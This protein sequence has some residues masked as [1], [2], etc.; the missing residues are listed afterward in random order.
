M[1]SSNAKVIQY[2]SALLINLLMGL[3]KKELKEAIEGQLSQALMSI[4]Q[5]LSAT[6][7]PPALG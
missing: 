2:A 6:S 4:T 3:E 5:V 1:R 7:L